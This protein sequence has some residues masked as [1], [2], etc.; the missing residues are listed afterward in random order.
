LARDDEQAWEYLA[1]CLAGER[2]IDVD[3]APEAL[4]RFVGDDRDRPRAESVEVEG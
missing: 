1:E 4:P 2:E 3:R